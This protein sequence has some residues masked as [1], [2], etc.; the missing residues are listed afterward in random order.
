MIGPY[1]TA[2]TIPIQN[3][4]QPRDRLESQQEG[5]VS[6]SVM[7]SLPQVDLST[8]SVSGSMPGMMAGNEV[9]AVYCYG[10][11]ILAWRV[12]WGHDGVVF[13]FAT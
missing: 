8:L 9:L 4:G 3:L 1:G 10:R 13:A 11:L 6:V 2:G 7:G 12:G 5:R